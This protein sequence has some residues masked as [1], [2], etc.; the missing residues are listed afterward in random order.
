[1]KSFVAVLGLGAV[2]AAVVGAGAPGD[3]PR[4]QVE[5]ARSPGGQ[6]TAMATRTLA[7]LPAIAPDQPGGRF[8]GGPQVPGLRPAGFFRTARIDGRW[9]LVDP[10]GRLFIHRGVVSVRPVGSPGA[11]EVF[12][13]EFGSPAGWAGAT[14]RLLKQHGFNGTGAWTAE[15]LQPAAHQLVHT[16]IWNFMSSYGR[17]RG[18]THVKPGHTGYPGDCPFIFDRE[19]PG[20]CDEHAGQLA[21]GKD[22][23]WLLGHFTDNELPWHQRM[24]D[25]YLALPASDQGRVAAA[26]WLAARRGGG[27]ASRITDPEREAFL[28][29]AA[30]TYFRIVCGAIRRHDPNHLVLGPRFHGGALAQPALFRTA[31][32]HLD[33]IAVNYYHAWTPDRGRL[34]AWAAASG[35]PVLVTEWYAKGVDSGMPNHSGAGWLVKT[36]ADRGRFYQ[37]FTLGLLESRVC[38]GWHWFRYADNDPQEP[39]TDPSN[40]DSNKGILTNRY[41]PYQPLLDAMREINLRSHA[42]V[43]HFDS[44]RPGGG[45]PAPGL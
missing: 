22:D 25:R 35:K 40:R 38:V 36:Q 39:G 24:L 15:D 37:N 7:D 2:L 34:E 1:M 18:G 8:G 17:K 27:G 10:E 5:V 43:R 30:D 41:Q 23:P 3:M 16:R 33:V 12:A 31:G 6:W 19:F 4:R 9:W 20:F 26:R 13:R 44:R 29:H 32:R 21:A 28:E 14:A 42:L 11:R 45:R